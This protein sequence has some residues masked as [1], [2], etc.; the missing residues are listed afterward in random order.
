MFNLY[1]VYELNNWLQNPSKN[2]TLK[3]AYFA[4]SN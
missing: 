4:K 3:I 1:L 2:F